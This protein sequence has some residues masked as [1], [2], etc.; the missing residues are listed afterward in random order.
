MKKI[1]ICAVLILF[2]ISAASCGK[3]SSVDC[4]ALAEVLNEDV[5]F[6]E[7]LT[8]MDNTVAEQY[9]NINPSNYTEMTA[10]VGTKAVCDEFV[11]VKTKSTSSVRSKLQ[12][13]INSMKTKYASY[14]PAETSKLDDALITEYKDAVVLIVSPN[15][16]A[17]EAVYNNYLKRKRS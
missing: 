8:W 7:T 11:V 2:V 4:E 9:F 12:E 15:R 14:R 13:H 1:F 6:D 10:Y 17:A 5:M 16:D 3:I